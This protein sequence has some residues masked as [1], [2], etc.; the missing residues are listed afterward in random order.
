MKSS[1][2]Q[3]MSTNKLIFIE[4]N[5]ESLFYN[6]VIDSG[7]FYHYLHNQLDEKCFSNIY[8]HYY[9]ID[10]LVI[11]KGTKVYNSELRKLST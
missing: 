10:Y 6:S 8:S 4:G 2:L 7:K 11:A 3:R 9:W 1:Y 5:K